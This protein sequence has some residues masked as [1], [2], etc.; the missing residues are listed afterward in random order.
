MLGDSRAF[1]G[2]STDDIGRAKEFYGETLGLR[3]SEE[4][5]LLTLRLAGDT[6]VLVYPKGDGHTPATFTVLNFPVDD[7]E[8]TVDALVG[9]GVVFERYEG[10]GQDERGIARQEGPAIAWFRDPAG[11]VLSVLQE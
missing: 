6:T 9:L 2:F 5:G 3:V 11:N 10:F 1:S 7:I 8:R 4:H